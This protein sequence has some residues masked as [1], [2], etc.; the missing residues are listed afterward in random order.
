VRDKS[1]FSLER[2]IQKLTSELADFFGIA[3]RGRIAVGAAADLVVFDLATLDPG[4]L[5]RVRDLPGDEERLVADQPKGIEHVFVN[6][7]AITEH[8]RSLVAE[9]TARPGQILRAGRAMG[10]SPS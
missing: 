8:G 9:M 4:P 1:V 2:A 10:G 3:D 6:G 7:V 5:R